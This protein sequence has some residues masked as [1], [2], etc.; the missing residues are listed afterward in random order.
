MEHCKKLVLVPHETGKN[1]VGRTPEVLMNDL[2]REMQHILKQKAEDREKWKLYEQALQ[3][4][5]YFVNER[6]KNRGP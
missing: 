3:K 4:Y 1:P 2:D 6:K 5:L